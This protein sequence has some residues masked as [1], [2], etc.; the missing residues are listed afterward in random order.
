M[1]LFFPE[2]FRLYN[3]SAQCYP[4]FIH[5]NNNIKW[6]DI[7]AVVVELM[8]WNIRVSFSDYWYSWI[9]FQKLALLYLSGIM[10]ATLSVIGKL[11]H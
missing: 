3:R 4:K 6:R 2:L 7:Y 8:F 11:L 9:I 1:R 5:K 10:I